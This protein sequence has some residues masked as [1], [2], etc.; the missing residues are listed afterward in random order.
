MQGLLA[1]TCLFACTS[2]VKSEYYVGEKKHMRGVHNGSSVFTA[3]KF[4]CLIVGFTA[5]DGAEWK[6][7]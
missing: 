6:Y 7:G 2:L 1:M 5:V 3:F 4:C